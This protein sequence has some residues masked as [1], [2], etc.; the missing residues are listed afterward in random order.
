MLR[1]PYRIQTAG[2]G[3]QPLRVETRPAIWPPLWSKVDLKDTAVTPKYALI[4]IERRW[5]VD[6]DRIGS[7]AEHPFRK[8]DDLY[9]AG[10]RLRLRRV[11]TR[12]G[13]VVY[14]LGKKYGKRDNWGEPVTSLYLTRDEYVVLASL[15]GARAGKVR[16]SV[17]GG[18]LDV[19]VSPRSGLAIFETEFATDEAART[20]CP[21]DFV[22][23]EVT[24]DEN[25]CGRTIAETP[26]A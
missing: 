19:Y 2:A 14:K 25:Y 20:Y 15:V 17:A 4:E 7:L 3:L 6:L 12:D 10:S 1:Q 13:E 8:I 26:P 21:P 22:T 24:S 11:E 23:N 5:L 18:S 16:Y 9:I